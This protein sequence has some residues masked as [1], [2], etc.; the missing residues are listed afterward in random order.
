[1]TNGLGATIGTLVA[2]EV[3]NHYCTWE[4][5]FLVGNWQ[6]CWFIFAGFSF[7]VGITFAVVFKT[8][9]EENTISA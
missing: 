8:K 4:N 6:A 1:M 9:K 5:G 3:V 2:G 7:V